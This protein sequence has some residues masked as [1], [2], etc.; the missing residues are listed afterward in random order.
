MADGTRINLAAE[1]SGTDGGH[2]AAR[3][4]AQNDQVETGLGH[5]L[6]IPC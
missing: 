5:D 4:A 3:A 1:L 6:P 2:I